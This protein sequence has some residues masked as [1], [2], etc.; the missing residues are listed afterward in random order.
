M[1]LFLSLIYVSAAMNGNILPFQTLQLDFVLFRQSAYPLT[2]SNMITVKSKPT[3][4][5]TVNIP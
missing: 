5:I 4:K 3:N 1:F 2:Y